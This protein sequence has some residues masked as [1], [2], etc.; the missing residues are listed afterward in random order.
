MN[1]KSTFRPF[2]ILSL[3]LFIAGYV[4]AQ[5]ATGYVL[6]T[7]GEP[8]P[9]ANIFVKQIVSGTSADFEGKYYLGLPA[10]G[11]YDFIVTAIGYEDLTYNLDID[12]E[13]IIKDFRMVESNFELEEIVV[14]ASKRDPAYAIIQKV[15]DNKKTIWHP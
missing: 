6:N 13:D 11:E 10:K 2:F 12:E 4:H 14:K 7:A 3:L 15:I 1:N 5:S 8:V 9:Y